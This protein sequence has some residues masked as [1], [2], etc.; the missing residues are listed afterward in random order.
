[1]NNRHPLLAFRTAYIVFRSRQVVLDLGIEQDYGS[2]EPGKL[3]ALAKVS[4]P[5]YETDDPHELLWAGGPARRLELD[6]GSTSDWK[7]DND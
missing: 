2:L 6:N 3:A 7:V 4:L 1:M 5:E